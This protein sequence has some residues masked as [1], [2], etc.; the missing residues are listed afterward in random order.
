MYPSWQAVIKQSSRNISAVSL[1]CEIFL[2]TSGSSTGVSS[3]RGQAAVPINLIGSIVVLHVDDD[4]IPLGVVE[5]DNDLL[6]F[7]NEF[8]AVL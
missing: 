7:V 2:Q 5:F 3:N 8:V 4:I 1:S 6:L